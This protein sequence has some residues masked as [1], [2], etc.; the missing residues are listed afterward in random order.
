M[1]FIITSLKNTFK[2]FHPFKLPII[3]KTLKYLLIYIGTYWKIDIDI[4]TNKH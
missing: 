1:V 3:L 4:C 2:L